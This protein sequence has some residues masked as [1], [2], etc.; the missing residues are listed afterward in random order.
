MRPACRQASRLPQQRKLILF[1]FSQRRNW[2]NSLPK[3]IGTGS[4][5]GQVPVPQ[6]CGRGLFSSRKDAKPQRNYGP[7][8]GSCNLPVFRRGGLGVFGTLQPATQNCGDPYSFYILAKVQIR[9]SMRAIKDFLQ[10]KN[11][12]FCTRM[13]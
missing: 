13:G 7:P 6:T 11:V 9:K 2:G 10:W 1:L 5:K 12:I 8:L 4:Y 3:C